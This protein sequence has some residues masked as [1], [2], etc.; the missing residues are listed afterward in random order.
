MR[1]NFGIYVHI[2]FCQSK[3][4]YCNFVSGCYKEEIISKYF[5]K[6]WKEIE[7][8]HTNKLVTS[9]FFGGG[10]PSS[11]SHKY[12]VK[13]LEIIKNHFRIAKNVEISL[14]ANPNSV[15]LEKLNA[16]FNAGF[17]R[18]SFG[19][20]SLN[21]ETLKFL[22]RLHTK[23]QALEAIK[24]ANSVGF[25]NINADI[26]LGV[27]KEENFNESIQD[28]SM[29]GVTHIS[30]Y[31][32]ILEKD[33][34]LYSLVKQKK[35]ELL[36]EDESI[37]QYDVIKKIL[38]QQGFKRYE[39]SN[40]AKAGFECKHNLN[41]WTCGEYIGFGVSAHSYLNNRRFSNSDVIENYLQDKCDTKSEFISKIKQFE[42]L[43]MLG[44]RTKKGVSLKALK[45]VGFNPLKN[46][47]V[48]KLLSLNI[49]RLTK[50]HLKITNKFFGVANQII[51]KIIE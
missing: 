11:V 30:A 5:E 15:N 16:Y 31:M 34:K 43:I 12:I 1:T 23:S 44:L 39:I 28:L 22:G 2:P 24:L 42:E 7:N 41:Y 6:L 29:A 26:L 38:K 13:T 40:F 37:D 50:T 27:S 49:I 10:T 9:I 14:E 18:I 4:V 36:S 8:F 19:V 21:D 33:T 20:Q 46:K 3:C 48:L 51:L 47:N 25:Q 32:L 35:V 45:N 17:N